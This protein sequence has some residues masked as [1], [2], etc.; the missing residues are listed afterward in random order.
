MKKRLLA[1]GIALCLLMGLFPTTALAVDSDNGA[2]PA[3]PKKVS[4]VYVKNI[5]NDDSG[6]G[7][8]ENP[9]ATL[10]KAVEKAEDGAIIQLLS[11]LSVTENARITD[12]HLTITSEESKIYTLTRGTDF[13]STLDNRQS[14]YNPGFIEV[15]TNGSEASENASSVMLTNIILDDN[16]IHEGTYFAQTNVD[17]TGSTNGNLDHVQDSMITAHGLENRA[18]HVIL[19]DGAVLKDFGGMSAV[20]GTTNAHI[21][22]QAGSVIYDEA[23]TDRKASAD[24][25]AEGETGPAGAVWLQG[26]EFVMEDGA[27]IK[28]VVGRAVYADGGTASIGGTIS[29][30][31][32]DKDMWQGWSG[33]AVH[34]RGK[35]YAVLESTGRIDTIT[36]EHAS[37]RGAIVTNGSRGNGLYD[38]EMKAG[39][40]ISGVTGFPVL[41]SNYG[42]EL[43]SGT[44]E[45]CSNDYIIGGFAQ[46]TTI[47]NTALIHKNITTQGDAKSIIYTSN[48][49]KVYMN[50]TLKD[51]DVGTAA[52]YIINQTGGGAYLEI[53][54]GAVIQGK[55]KNYGVYINA[56]GSKCVMNGGTISHFGRGVYC[57]G[58]ANNKSATFIMNG[59]TITEND[60]GVYFSGNSSASHSIVDLVGG[61]ITKN[62]QGYQIYS[63]G[64]YNSN[65][66]NE[67]LFINS[68][69]LND[70][71]IVNLAFGRVTLDED[72][73]D[74]SLGK[75]SPDAANKIEGDV[76]SEKGTGW[77]NQSYSALWFKPTTESFHFTMPRPDVDN[78]LYA[79][80]IPLNEEGTPTD[81][82]TL[83]LIQLE[84]D[85]TTGV[86]TTTDT[87]DISLTSLTPNQSYALMLIKSPI[88]IIRP[89][90][91]A[92]YVTGDDKHDGESYV[93]CF[94]DPRYEGIP[95][96]ATITVGGQTWDPGS[97][98]DAQYPFTINYY[99]QDGTQIK[100]DHAPG[101]YIAKTEILPGLSVRPT[102]IL[103]NGQ[104]MYF[105]TGTL[106]IRAA[107]NA[108]EIEH[109]EEV[110]SKVTTDEPA[111]Q[112]EQAVA[113]MPDDVTYLVNGITGQVPNPG[114]DIRL[115]QD[116]VLSA[117]GTDEDQYVRMMRQC[118]EKAHPDLAVSPGET[119]RQY[120]MKYLDLIDAHD[121]NL[122]ITPNLKYGQSYDIYIPYPSGTDKNYEFQLFCFEDLDRTY[123]EKDYGENVETVIQNSKVSEL[124]VVATDFGLK[125]TMERNGRLGAMALT[126]QQK[127]HI[128]TATAGDGGTI[129]PNGAVSV[130]DTGDQTFTITPASGYHIADVKVD[131]VSQGTV[132]TYTFT[133]V[134]TNHT[135]E[136]TFAKDSSGGGESGGGTTN[137]LIEA[138]A[139]TGGTISPA[140]KV[141]VS[142]GSDKTFTIAP[143]KGYVLSSVLVD[144]KDVGTAG[145]YTFEN[146]RSGHT[147]TA[148]FAKDMTDP[149]NTGV[150]DWLDTV[151]HGRYF[152]GYEDDTFRPD[153]PMTRAEAAQM[154][155]NLL[156]NKDVPVTV[157]FEDVPAEAWYAKAVGVLAS[158]EK[159]EGVGQNRFSPERAITRAEFT[160]IAMRFANGIPAG[161]N[162][163]S[164]VSP[165]DW[166]YD[167]VVGAIQ[168]GWINGYEDE[169]F[170]PNHTITR[171]EVTAITNR[172]LGRSAD[173]DYVDQHAEALHRFPD[174]PAT[175]WAY[176]SI[177][178]AAN[179]HDYTKDGSGEHWKDHH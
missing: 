157:S 22:M 33:A 155:Y 148:S 130:R 49:S 141:W 117:E 109:I 136:A 64:I 80:Y 138:S 43:L 12:K 146:V 137:Y 15:T 25:K 45:N 115:L 106:S 83:T 46:N 61:N 100:D 177:A 7:T 93:N 145:T 44:I 131:G 87:L 73:A 150:A 174:V 86:V 158:L 38:F 105:G 143:A 32:G 2:T 65:E 59:G 126:W 8:K 5:G 77:E 139:G 163:F 111:E 13:T 113:V 78:I 128:I 71:T 123:T 63:Y 82:A 23:V 135:I 118:L 10:A 127:A 176:Y 119:P 121:S 103:I 149:E 24:Q 134:T 42:T 171:A 89:V 53:G 112:V 90:N 34:I 60:Y 31:A 18:V 101:T 21:A 47:G 36:G 40:I 169:T 153:R 165:D 9:Y 98:S 39:S 125:V 156:R 56:S 175:Y 162:T 168:Y 129:A 85:N 104:R 178:E 114:A 160:T 48:A 1:I 147:I 27:E 17:V 51:N 132:K 79:G 154:F 54:D 67:R 62:K 37:Y 97:H 74:I 35:G 6:D 161:E 102:D 84:G 30:I 55:D 92:K 58:K 96:N 70:D 41:F 166:F 68:G 144:G 52:F 172:M 159:I 95:E 75:A 120:A 151:T 72:Y 91:L 124:N 173:K 116:E 14:H 19:G 110:S 133:N 4:A 50:G 140:G 3:P 57:R 26:A 108:T 142:R 122:I 20:Y 88:L 11:D 179:A 69:V 99:E 167:Q 81:D 164:D 94:P 66:T 16:G 29:N 28:N 170:R 107:S 76:T 152:H